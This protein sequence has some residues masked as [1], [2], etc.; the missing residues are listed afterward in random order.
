MKPSLEEVRGDPLNAALPWFTVGLPALLK[1]SD[2][3]KLPT[4]YALSWRANVEREFQKAG[5]GVLQTWIRPVPC[6]WCR[7]NIILI[8]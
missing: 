2:A 4:T 8:S 3:N 1:R 5:F 6:D 7:R